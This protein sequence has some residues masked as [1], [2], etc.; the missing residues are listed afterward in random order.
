MLYQLSYSQLDFR[1]EEAASS[2]ARL[3]MLAARRLPAM[4]SLTQR[5]RGRLRAD[6][7]AELSAPDL[8]RRPKVGR[9]QILVLGM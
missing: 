4:L 9:R 7:H 6:G 3:L 5:L 2:Q 8:A 1:H